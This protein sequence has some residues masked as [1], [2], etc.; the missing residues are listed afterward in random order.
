MQ[1]RH[2]ALA[3]HLARKLAP[4]YVVHGDEP[5]LVLEAG[6]AIR[7]AAR[8][9]GCGEREVFIV[10]GH[11]RW[12]SLVAAG[13]SPG[14]FS[15]RRLIEVSIP[16]GKPGADGAS[17]LVRFAAHLGADDVTLVTLPRLDRATLHSEWFTALAEAGI[18]VSVPALERTEL[19]AWIAA[20]LA[21]NH[22]R[23]GSDTL[24]FLADRCEGNLVAAHQEIEKL[25][26]LLPQGMLAHDDVEDVVA[27]VARYDVRDLSEAWLSGDAVRMLRIV[28][29]LR[30]MGEPVNLALW[31]FAEDL[32]AITAVQQSLQ[33]GMAMAA[34]LRGARAWGRRQAALERATRRVAPAAA[35]PLLHGLAG[36]DA[37][38]KGYGAGDPWNA[39][40]AAALVLCGHPAM[41]AFAGPRSLVAA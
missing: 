28:A 20:R 18:A 12:D 25:A 8:R 33:A 31:Q 27:D 22:Q 9:A 7:A 26:L 1:L 2:D 36:I 32:R 21:R 41:L 38:A 3:G 40:V 11:F 15:A 37:L 23:A 17:A 4:L 39:L 14:L 10:E 19:P 35:A 13:A 6:D 29:V 30:G 24:A 16:T 5:L 34:A